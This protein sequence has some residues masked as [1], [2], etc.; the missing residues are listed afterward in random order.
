MKFTA[1]K[2]MLS[3]IGLTTAQ[4]TN[5]LS[6]VGDDTQKWL[7][8]GITLAQAFLAI[9]AHFRTP[10]GNKVPKSVDGPLQ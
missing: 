1:L 8:I 7:A 10:A 9:A 3:Q 4:T 6:D 2:N 5:Q